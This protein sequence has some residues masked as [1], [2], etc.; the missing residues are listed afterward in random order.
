MGMEIKVIFIRHENGIICVLEGLARP[1][2]A[3]VE[4]VGPS[5]WGPPCSIQLLH[6]LTRSAIGVRRWCGNL[7][8]ISWVLRVL[9]YPFSERFLSF[10][11]NF[12]TD[13]QGKANVKTYLYCLVKYWYFKGQ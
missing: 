13:Y 12:V 5:L 9:L 1:G 6:H 10:N 4:N 3:V 8:S 7:P 2:R 11:L